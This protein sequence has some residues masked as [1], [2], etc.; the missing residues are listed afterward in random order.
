M[1][2]EEHGAVN[3]FG[4]KT[5]FKDGSNKKHEANAKGR[6]GLVKS[7][8]R[9]TFDSWDMALQVV[10]AGWRGELAREVQRQVEAKMADNPWAKAFLVF[11]AYWTAFFVLRLD[12]APPSDPVLAK[13]T[14]VVLMWVC[15]TLGGKLMGKFGMPGLLG[16]LLSGII[17]KNAIS[18]PGGTYDYNSAVCPD[19]PMG[20][21]GSGSASGSGA[22]RMLAGG[23]DYSNP[24]WCI[25]KS[26]NGL[27]D[28]WASDIITFGLTI[29]FMRGG[30]ELDIELIKKAMPSALY[31]TFFPGCMEALMVAAFSGLIFNGM[32][33]TMGATLGFILAAVSPAVVVG[34]M[35]DLKKQGYGVKQNI[36]TLVVA[37]ASMDDVVAITGT[38]PPFHDLP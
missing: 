37:A 9:I 35:F 32:G 21:S 22:G 15:S 4:K 7:E 31:L 24:Q 28:S 36:P 5:S 13:G 11:L 18:Y 16:N 29:I 27:P 14:A 25:G 1:P 23:I 2:D 8:T 6:W 33:F 26:I 20:A 3:V 12:A 30:L 34:A 10:E 19:P 38:P 17:L